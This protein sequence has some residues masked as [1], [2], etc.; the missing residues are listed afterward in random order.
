MLAHL[1]DEVREFRADLHAADQGI[2]DSINGLADKV[3]VQNGRIGRL[4][5]DVAEHKAA[6]AERFALKREVFLFLG[7]FLCGAFPTVLAVYLTR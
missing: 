5:V 4:E 1:L 3:K 6:Q 2:R 7:A